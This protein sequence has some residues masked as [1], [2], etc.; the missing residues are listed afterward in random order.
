MFVQHEDKYA[1]PV[2]T[3]LR[4]WSDPAFLRYKYAR[5]GQQALAIDTAINPND[6]LVLSVYLTPALPPG[7]LRRLISVRLCAEQCDRWAVTSGGGRSGTWQLRL[8]ELASSMS[9][10]MS[11]TPAGDGSSMFVVMGQIVGPASLPSPLRG[12][13]ERLGARTLTR[14]LSRGAQITADWLEI[15]GVAPK[16]TGVTTMPPA[17]SSATAPAAE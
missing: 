9:G 5:V 14:T 2:E 13:L 11:L 10:T 3:L 7:L 17:L 1:Y 4:T 16:L 15:H 6:P 12:A 8:D